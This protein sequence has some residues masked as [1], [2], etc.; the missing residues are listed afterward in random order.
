MAR[1]A[2]I[3]LT[4]AALFGA[5]DP[6]TKVKELKSGT[7]IRVLRKGSTTPVLGKFGDANDENLILVVKNEEIA[8]ARGLVDRLD[9]RPGQPRFVKETKTKVE[10]ANTASEP[11]AGMNGAGVGPGYSSSTSVGIQGKGD[12]ET[13]YRRPTPPPKLPPAK[14]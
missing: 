3:L 13:L 4:V 5:D 2:L 1:L 6:W 10:D 7:D 8:I 11:K 12:F 9:Y 14:Q